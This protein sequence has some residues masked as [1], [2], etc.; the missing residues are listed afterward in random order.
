[1]AGRDTWTKDD[2]A[3]PPRSASTRGGSIGSSQR[4]GHTRNK[5]LDPDDIARLQQAGDQQLPPSP[6]D[7]SHHG[8]KECEDDDR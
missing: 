3:L 8:I 6:G 4:G 7:N 5:S 1:M 2:L